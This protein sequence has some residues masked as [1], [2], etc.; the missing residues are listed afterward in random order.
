MFSFKLNPT[1]YK[2]YKLNANGEYNPAIGFIILR[3]VNSLLTNLYWIK[4]YDSIR[5]FYPENKIVIIDDNSNYH[6][7][8]KKELYNTII[9]QSKFPGRGELLPYYYYVR[10][11]WFDNAFIMHDSV[12]MQ[13]YI[14]VN[15]DKYTILWW[16]NHLSD[17]V[18]NETRIIDL[19]HNPEL[20]AFYKSKN[21][22]GCFGGMTIISHDFVTHINTKYNLNLLLPVITN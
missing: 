14:N 15:I 1:I 17:D 22:V 7:I 20:T 4:C 9:I 16:F 2:K 3:H 8:T 5:T 21:W 11:K 13:S 10:N 19:F 12:F 6:F 18:V